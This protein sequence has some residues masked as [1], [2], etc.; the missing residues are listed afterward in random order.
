[1]YHFQVR[2]IDANGN[3]VM[4]NNN[5]QSYTFTTSAGSSIGGVSVKSIQQNAATIVWSTN[6]S[7]DSH[8]LYATSTGALSTNGWIDQSNS[9]ITASTTPG[10]F[11]HTVTLSG[12]ASSTTYYFYVKSTDNYNNVLVD[13]NQGAYYNFVT[14]HPPVI[15]NVHVSTVQPNWA[16]I[17]WT[18]D[19][20]ATSSI[21]YDLFNNV[22]T[23]TPTYSQSISS[24]ALTISH[25]L[26]LT[27]LTASTTYV[28]RVLVTD[29]SGDTVVDDNGG[30]GYTFTTTPGAVISGV[31]VQSIQDTGATVTWTTSVMS[32]SHV[33]YA[34]SLPDLMSG[35]NVF[36]QGNINAVAST[37][38]SGNASSTPDTSAS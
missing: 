38:P 19:Q 22:G 9:S 16:S 2:S 5:G 1:M 29:T 10:Y 15:T 27:G 20:S 34:A 6:V 14:G 31:N 33:L 23:S 21:Q 4:D 35:V 25:R 18:T 24:D 12:L 17:D 28:Y 37:T 32:D 11:T 3:S 7:S 30:N 8:V 13:N 26:T 36:D